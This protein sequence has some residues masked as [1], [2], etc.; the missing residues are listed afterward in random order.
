V[1]TLGEAKDSEVGAIAVEGMPARQSERSPQKRGMGT[2]FPPVK[3][4]A[5]STT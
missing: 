4:Y 2:K 3:R 5:E 1:H